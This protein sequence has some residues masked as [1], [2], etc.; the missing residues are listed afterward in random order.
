MLFLL[1]YSTSRMTWMRPVKRSLLPPPATSSFCWEE[2]FLTCFSLPDLCSRVLLPWGW[3]QSPAVVWQGLVPR[4]CWEGQGTGLAAWVGGHAALNP[5]AMVSPVCAC[6]NTIA[7]AVFC[8]WWA[9]ASC[10]LEWEEAC[11]LLHRWAVGQLLEE[12]Q[13]TARIRKGCFLV[14]CDVV[15]GG[16]RQAA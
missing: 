7:L 13:V 16:G 2:Q 1:T 4:T 10:Q 14:T 8:H 15:V 5:H 11:A 3:G 12:T 9:G 6:S